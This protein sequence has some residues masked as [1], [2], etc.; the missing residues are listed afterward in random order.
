MQEHQ[1]N[2]KMLNFCLVLLIFL[3]FELSG[4]SKIKQKLSIFMF[5]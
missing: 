3:S 5:S 4:L 2:M 1:E